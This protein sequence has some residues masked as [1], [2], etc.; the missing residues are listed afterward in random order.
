MGRA[1][2][3]Y[4]HTTD[5]PDNVPTEVATFTEPIAAALEIQQQVAVNCDWALEKSRGEK[6]NF[7]FSP[8]RPTHHSPTNTNKDSSSVDSPNNGL[9]LLYWQ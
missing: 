7:L 9:L 6:V 8:C 4:A 3:L 1:I 5:V 2:H